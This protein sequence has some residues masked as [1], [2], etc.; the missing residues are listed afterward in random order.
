MHFQTIRPGMFNYTISVAWLLQCSLGSGVYEFILKL[1]KGS[2]IS[3]AIAFAMRFI[4]L[5]LPVLLFA[6]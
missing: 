4:V 5:V 2:S 1:L 6:S 3:M